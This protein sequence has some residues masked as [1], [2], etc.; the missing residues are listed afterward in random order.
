M[1]GGGGAEREW[2]GKRGQQLWVG[3]EEEEV[4]ERNDIAEEDEEEH[5]FSVGGIL[6]SKYMYP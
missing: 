3:N 4:R 6:T 5:A 1:G 2:R